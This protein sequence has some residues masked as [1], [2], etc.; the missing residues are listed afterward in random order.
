MADRRPA[1]FKSVSSIYAQILKSGSIGCSNI[2]F[3]DQ[4]VSLPGDMRQYMPHFRD[5]QLF[6]CQANR[7]IG[8]G[9]TENNTV[10]TGSGKSPGKHRCCPDLF[11]AF[12][13][14]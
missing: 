4:A 8:P 5:D 7:S 10:L 2:T 11:V 1:G 6:G 9:D 12:L 3:R 13:T 14:E